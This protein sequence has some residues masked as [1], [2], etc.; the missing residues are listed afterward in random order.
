[1]SSRTLASA[2]ALA[3]RTSPARDTGIADWGTFSVVGADISGVGDGVGE[4]WAGPWATAVV[5][6]VEIDADAAA[7]AGSG[8]LGTGIADDVGAGPATPPPPLPK[9]KD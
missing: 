9:V 1:M 2:A 7:G 3:S 8:A 6:G 4:F 5:L